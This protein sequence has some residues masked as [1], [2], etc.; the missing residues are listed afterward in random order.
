MRLSFLT[1]N[2]NR[3]SSFLFSLGF[4]RVYYALTAFL[5]FIY[6]ITF[7]AG[8]PLSEWT[9][10]MGGIMA[11]CKLGRTLLFDFSMYLTF[12]SYV[13]ACADISL[14]YVW[15]CMVKYD[16]YIMAFSLLGRPKISLKKAIYRHF[17]SERRP[18]FCIFTFW[19]SFSELWF[20]A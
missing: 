4:L 20:M 18:L 7:R 16:L 12:R 5:I 10:I 17:S 11:N 2:L 14:W 1:I 9:K 19:T 6:N 15:G 8:N 3:L 13:A